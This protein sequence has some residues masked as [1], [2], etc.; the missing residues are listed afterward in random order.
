MLER[1]DENLCDKSTGYLAYLLY[2]AQGLFI[3]QA[4]HSHRDPICH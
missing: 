4:D 2:F 1:S 3:K